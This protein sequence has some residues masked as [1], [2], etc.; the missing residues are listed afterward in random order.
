M[1]VNKFF[2][3]KVA[4]NAGLFILVFLPIIFVEVFIVGYV[5]TWMIFINDV[6]VFDTAQ[7]VSFGQNIISGNNYWLD[8]AI[9]S[10]RITAFSSIFIALPLFYFNR[11][12]LII[13]DHPERFAEVLF[14]I[15]LVTINFTGLYATGLMLDRSSHHWWPLF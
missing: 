3:Q 2:T 9:H 1:R 14:I 12:I 5:S 7:E 4:T 10:T 8:S 15:S 6:M 11:L 13:I